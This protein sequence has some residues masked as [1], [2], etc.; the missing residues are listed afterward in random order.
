MLPKRLAS[1]TVFPLFEYAC[2]SHSLTFGSG[3][4]GYKVDISYSLCALSELTKCA[5]KTFNCC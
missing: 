3:G 2:I 5:S 1:T 4:S